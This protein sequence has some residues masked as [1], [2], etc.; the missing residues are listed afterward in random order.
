MYFA[1]IIAN[2]FNE[3]FI[4]KVEIN[5]IKEINKNVIEIF[6][7]LNSQEIKDLLRFLEVY[8]IE[9]F[10]NGINEIRS[11][12][13]FNKI[14][15]ICKTCPYTKFIENDIWI[16]NRFNEWC[17]QVKFCNFFNDDYPE[18]YPDKIHHKKCFDCKFMEDHTD[19]SPEKNFFCKEKESWCCYVTGCRLW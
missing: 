12:K 18:N 4:N 17:D 13:E 3:E 7:K 9:D 19:I 1:G 15:D 2:L 8:S 10:V 5:N 11:K 14:N 6:K 16:C